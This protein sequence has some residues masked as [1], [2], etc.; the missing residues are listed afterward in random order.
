M[1]ACKVDMYESRSLIPCTLTQCTGMNQVY[2]SQCIVAAAIL[3]G[4]KMG[5]VLM[6]T[7]CGVR[8]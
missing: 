5:V 4:R 2:K 8:D 6:G 3:K 7:I 1:K